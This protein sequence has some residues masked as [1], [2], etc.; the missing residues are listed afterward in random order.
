MVQ[1]SW[2]IVLWERK[3]LDQSGRS[4]LG[5]SELS[6]GRLLH[7]LAFERAAFQLTYIL[8]LYLF[9]KD[10]V[11]FS[12]SILTFKLNNHQYLKNG[13]TFYFK[14]RNEHGFFYFLVSNPT[15]FLHLELYAR[16]LWVLKKKKISVPRKK[17]NRWNWS[18]CSRFKIS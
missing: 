16:M 18:K 5:S 4:N 15:I 9:Q 13:E 2:Q 7:A 8:S 12:L 17:E 6:V 10:R 11:A 3:K 14:N 1:N